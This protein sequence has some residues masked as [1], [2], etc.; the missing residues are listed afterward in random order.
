MMMR[1]MPLPARPRLPTRPS[2]LVRV[3][4]D[5]A[6][7]ALI[8]FAIIMP[9]LLMLIMGTMEFGLQIYL[10]AVLEGVMQQAGRNTSL[11]SGSTNLSAIHTLVE[12]RVKTIMPSATVTP[13]RKTYQSFSNVG[14]PE[15]FV[16]TNANGIHDATECFTDV[17][18]NGTYDT[19]L[20]KSGT[21][22]ANDVV[23]YTET[24]T[25]NSLIPAGRYLGI[26]PTTSI[27]ATTILRNQPYN[28]QGSWAATQV[29]P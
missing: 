3:G 7:A 5:R 23:E 11:E 6:G 28:A 15:D 2:M 16:D 21:G 8:E 27:S 25:Y 13:T 12:G 10:R 18:G 17:N 1:R 29:C 4:A 20:G 26:S 14:K 24:V 22:G 19:D 9:V